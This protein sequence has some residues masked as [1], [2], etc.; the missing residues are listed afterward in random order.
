[1][2]YYP[3][4]C[5]RQKQLL[6]T[7]ALRRQMYLFT[8][9]MWAQR[10]REVCHNLTD[11][12]LY[13][14]NFQARGFICFLA[15]VK[16]EQGAQGLSRT[17]C[18]SSSLTLCVMTVF[19]SIQANTKHMLLVIERQPAKLVLL[20]QVRGD[21]RALLRLLY[22]ILPLKLLFFLPWVYSDAT[23]CLKTESRE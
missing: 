22:S 16:Q 6:L 14:D 9:I 21:D 8:D 7:V 11:V 19:I 20:S 5:I 23:L 12:F 1:M 15:E 4:F 13:G 10:Q 17:P 2:G 3:V 18:H